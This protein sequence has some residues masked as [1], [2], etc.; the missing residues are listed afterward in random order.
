MTSIQI[1]SLTK[2]IIII[3]AAIITARIATQGLQTWSR[4]LR[5]KADFEVARNL[6]RSMYKL[7]DELKYCRS[8]WVQLAEFPSDFD[9]KNKTS[10][11]EAN[12][13]AY[14]YKKRWK[15]VSIHL[16]EFEAQALEGEALWGSDFKPKTDELRQCARNLQVS[17]D[18]M[19]NNFANSGE[20]FKND[21][22]FAKSVKSDI[23]A[24]HDKT[25]EL[26]IKIN[27]AIKS[28]ESD[29][30]PHFKRS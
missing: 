18:A 23:W 25:N 6:I 3:L 13:Y 14:I 4:E 5:G 10:D 8:P 17:F 7:R 15:P 9:S 21:L 16:Q 22:E 2:D 20:S 28:I 29:V 30:R 1:I 27:A 24:T 12:A 19:V 26:T 11:S